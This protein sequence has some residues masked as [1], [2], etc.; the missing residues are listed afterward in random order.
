MSKKKGNKIYL[1]LSI[2]FFLSLFGSFLENEN[3]TNKNDVIMARIVSLVLTI[4]FTYKYI[5]PK[6][7][8]ERKD[9]IITKVEEKPKENICPKCGSSNINYQIINEVKIKN[10]G[11]GCF[12]WL[13]I[14]WWLEIILWVY[15][16]IPRLLFLIFSSQKPKII[17]VTKKIAICQNCG[18]SWD[19]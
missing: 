16:T 1:I 17:N 3:L 7:A 18:N 12:Y 14:G 9:K 6:E 2:L 10:N 11:M 5:K 19:I 4:F 8:K 15:F 13:F